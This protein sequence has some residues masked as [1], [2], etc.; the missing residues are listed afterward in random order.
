MVT[1]VYQLD[2]HSFFAGGRCGRDR[3]VVGFT[4]TYATSAYHHR[5]CEFESTV[6]FT[7]K[8]DPH[9]ITEILLKVALNTIKQT[10]KTFFLCNYFCDKGEVHRIQ[11]YVIKL[12]VF[13]ERLVVSPSFLVYSI[14][15]T[16]WS[17]ITEKLL[18]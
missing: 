16:D 1:I 11:S 4:T 3:M 14:D 9:D 5:C 12:S 10:N 8:T 2:L 7:N 18:N 13:Y 6:S 17:N 15:T